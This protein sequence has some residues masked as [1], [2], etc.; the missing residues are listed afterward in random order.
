MLCSHRIEPQHAIRVL[1]AHSETAICEHSI[2]VNSSKNRFFS[3]ASNE[4]RHC[5]Y[6]VIKALGKSM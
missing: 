4:N 1:K 3:A 6:V 5:G 2:H